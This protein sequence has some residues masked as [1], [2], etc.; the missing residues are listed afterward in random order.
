[1]CGADQGGMTH[2]DE[3]SA[4]RSERIGHQGLIVQHEDTVAAGHG[5]NYQNAATAPSP[6]TRK[7]PPGVSG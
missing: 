5:T 7:P 3:G 4:A 6:A 2:A 1:M